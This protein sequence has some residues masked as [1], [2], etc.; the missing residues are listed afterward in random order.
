MGSKDQGSISRIMADGDQEPLRKL[1]LFLMAHK[2]RQRSSDERLSH[3]RIMR[4]SGRPMSCQPITSSE[5]L[6]WTFFMP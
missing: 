3:R 6:E 4:L 1:P 2:P 5:S